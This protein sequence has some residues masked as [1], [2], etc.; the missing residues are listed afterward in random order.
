MLELP[1]HIDLVGPCEPP[2]PARLGT[3][4]RWAGVGRVDKEIRAD[5][6]KQV[7]K[8]SGFTTTQHLPTF[9][10]RQRGSWSRCCQVQ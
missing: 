1:P 6:I 3:R 7:G 2:G 8:S 9:T 5:T 4:P 10:T